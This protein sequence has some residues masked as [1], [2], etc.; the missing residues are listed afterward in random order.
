[1]LDGCGGKWNAVSEGAALGGFVL[2]FATHEFINTEKE[3]V[4]VKQGKDQK[5]FFEK[6]IAFI[7]VLFI[8]FVSDYILWITVVQRG[9]TCPR[10]FMSNC[11]F[12]N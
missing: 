4:C 6:E 8:S 11:Y 2:A 10:S 9:V 12:F 1:M 5:E 3:T 7:A